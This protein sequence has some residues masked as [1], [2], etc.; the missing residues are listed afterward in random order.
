MSLGRAAVI[1]T[2]SWASA[3]LLAAVPAAGRG[4]TV[5]ERD[6]RPPAELLARRRVIDAERAEHAV[7]G[8]TAPGGARGETQQRRR[9]G[10]EAGP[11]APRAGDAAHKP[12]RRH[13]F[14]VAQPERPPP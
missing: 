7:G 1:G 13:P 8:G 4:K 12:R 10:K 2:P 11:A 3:G 5:V 9:A 6:A 14:F